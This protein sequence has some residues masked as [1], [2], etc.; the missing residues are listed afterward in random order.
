MK[1]S[2]LG[3]LGLAI[4]V[5]CSSA[6]KNDNSTANAGNG[7]AGTSSAGA[8]GVAAGGASGGTGGVAGGAAGEAAGGDAGTGGTAGEAGE[9]QTLFETGLY[10]DAALTTLAEGVMEFSPQ[11][12][13]WS[14]SASKR[15]FIWLPPD[16]Q[17]DTSDMDHWKFPVGTKVW[18]EFTRGDTRVETR[19]LMKQDETNWFMGAYKW[20]EDL[21]EATLVA[22]RGEQ[23]ALGTD[24]D[25][26]S[27]RECDDCHKG[28]PDKVLGFSAIQ[29]SHDGSAVNLAS[30][31]AAG[32]LSAPPAVDAFEVPGNP[33][34]RA[35]IGLLH[36][37]CG[38]CHSEFGSGYDR[39]QMELWL[40]VDTL[41]DL[42]Q[43]APY[44]TAVGT[45]LDQDLSETLPGITMRVI[46]GDPQHSA[47]YLRMASRDAAR[48]IAMPPI[49]TEL[50]DD[51]G[52]QLIT[53]WINALPP[54]PD[55]GPDGG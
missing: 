27:T 34:E 13:L 28:Q 53:D 9:P 33:T 2:L 43:T 40:K 52:L 48:L 38:Q 4:L 42:S 11:F 55:A 39:N 6:E 19:L 15:R 35:A 37:N 21:S 41:G 22:R 54:L 5:S 8:A 29:L 7:N 44:Q 46:P 30:I 50:T 45:P 51:P 1:R 49:G 32:L 31:K 23:N 10:A 24:H 26:P 16:T 3:I 18:K 25:I 17:I 14:D 12:P 47:L 36:A 20:S